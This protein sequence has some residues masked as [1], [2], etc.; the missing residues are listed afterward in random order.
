MI[1]LENVYKEYGENDD[2]VVALSNVNLKIETGKLTAVIGQS[3]SGK[4]TL[5]NLIGAL[6]KP[7]R[8]NVYVDNVDLATLNENELCEFRNKHIGFVFQ[9]FFLES[10]Y[11][12]LENV[13]MPLVIAGVDKKIRES[14]A[15][16]ILEK[17]NLINK[18]NTKAKDLSG[19]QKQ[20]VSIARALIGNPEIILADEPTGN[21]DLKSGDEIMQ[22]LKNLVKEGVTIILV[23]HN[24]NY[25]KMA[26]NI[27]T[28]IDGKVDRNWV[29]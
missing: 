10:E 7:T 18:I 19:G 11:T 20:K 5:L 14:R 24:L 17:L 4:T 26:D 1:F 15:K 12:V 25:S 28:I 9:S 16:E 8:G 21:L 27:I 2:K 23:T 22:I 29:I 6:D 3:G 13:V